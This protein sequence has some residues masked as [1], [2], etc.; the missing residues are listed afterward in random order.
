MAFLKSRP[1]AAAARH[2]AAL[3]RR[4]DD[5]AALS[6]AVHAALRRRLRLPR[7]AAAA[8]E[9]RPGRA[10]LAPIRGS[11]RAS[12]RISSPTD[13]DWET[14]RAGLRMVREIGR[15]APLAPFIAR[16]DRAR[17][18]TAAPTPR[19]TRISARPRSPCITRSAPARW[20]A[21]TDPTAVVDPRTQ[22]ARRR[23]AARRRCLGDAGPG[24]R[25]HQRAGDH[26]RRKGRRSD[27]RP[28]RR[29]RRS[30]SSGFRAR[31][32][33]R[34]PLYLSDDPDPDPARSTCR[35]ARPFCGAARRPAAQAPLS[36]ASGG[37]HPSGRAA[38]WP[39]GTGSR[40]AKLAAFRR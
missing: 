16:G 18:A 19:S 32:A 15:Q 22:G 6:S 25:Q 23:R 24:R 12:A 40:P 36:S 9:P 10:R 11:R 26:D 31:R 27:P 38:K 3:Q 7:R 39:S 13:D 29:S 1:D 14:L 21:E 37:P 30:M 4:A 20:A 34:L 5:G 33:A 8:G 17:P 2:P 35:G 28:R